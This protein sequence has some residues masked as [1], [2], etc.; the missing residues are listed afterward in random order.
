MTLGALLDVGADLQYLCSQL[1]KLNLKGY[2]ITASKKTRN[3]IAGT[4]VQVKVDDY[5]IYC[6]VKNSGP[7]HHKHSHGD[8]P[9]HVH[10]TESGFHH[11]GGKNA[12]KSSKGHGL[13][14]NLND[15]EKLILSSAL[16]DKV[17]ETSLKIFNRLAR[18][19][20]KVHGCKINEVHF[21]EVG[22][23]DSIIDIV[24]TA[25][26]L[27]YLGIEKICSSP[28]HLGCG[29]VQCAHGTLPVEA[30]A[31]MAMLEGVPVYSTGIKHEL[32]T[33]TGAAIIT[34]LA[35]AFQPIPEVVIERV[36]Y[37][38]GDGEIEIPNLLRVILAEQPP[39]AL[40]ML[41][42][43][44]DDMNPEFYSHLIPLLFEQGAVDVYLTPI[45]MKK[46]RPGIMLNVLC[47]LT[48]ADKLEETIF[49]ETTTL[50]VR[51]MPVNRN[52]LQREVRHINTKYGTIQVKLA[53][54]DGRILRVSPEYED[55]SRI[56]RAFKLPLQEVY[57]EV[58]QAAQILIS[59]VN[60]S[61]PED[62]SFNAT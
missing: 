23:V 15:I 19:E 31:T 16:S 30:P 61:S 40:M 32:V 4:D 57:R 9:G 47:P 29:F 17:K 49:V 2:T 36:G 59:T 5:S 45:I 6:P 28:L 3:D 54:R 52:S 12:D 50:G 20:A 24:G 14:R 60:Q 13:Q 38:V 48:L 25:I 53:V 34:S 58:S 10:H 21:H 7:A 27:D 8:E 41:E 26:C 1:A 46:N 62:N 11:E 18:A 37:G 55:C 43:N 42:S 56:A 35:E 33:P 44:I 51:R 22:A 39:A